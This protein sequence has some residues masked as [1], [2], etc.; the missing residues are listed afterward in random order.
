[1]TCAA[2]DTII[3][4]GIGLLKAS[5]EWRRLSFKNWSVQPPIV[6]M[7]LARAPARGRPM[8]RIHRDGDRVIS[9]HRALFMHRFEP[10]RAGRV[11]QPCQE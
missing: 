4:Y 9:A 7:A 2:A 6:A 3:S 11:R 8:T 1:M 10:F 5:T